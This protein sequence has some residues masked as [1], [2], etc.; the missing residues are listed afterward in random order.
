VVVADDT[1]CYVL[2]F[3]KYCFTHKCYISLIYISQ[4]KF[5][6]LTKSN[7]KIKN[8]HFLYKTNAVHIK[9]FS[10]EKSGGLPGCKDEHDAY[11]LS[12]L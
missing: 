9:N 10:L 3:G 12:C 11:T 7:V 8:L 5:V 4:I 6:H 2:V 1:C